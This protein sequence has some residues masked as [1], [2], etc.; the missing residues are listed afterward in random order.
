M[1]YR[2][3]LGEGHGLSAFFVKIIDRGHGHRGLLPFGFTVSD[4]RV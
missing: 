3:S 2:Q 1:A 4:E